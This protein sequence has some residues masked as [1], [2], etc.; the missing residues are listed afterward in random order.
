[1]HEKKKKND[2]VCFVIFNT[3][4]CVLFP[5]FFLRFPT[6]FTFFASI[7]EKKRLIFNDLDQFFYNNSCVILF[8][9]IFNFFPRSKNKRSTPKYNFFHKPIQRKIIVITKSID[10]IPIYF[11]WI[12]IYRP[13]RTLYL[14]NF[15]KYQLLKTLCKL[16]DAINPWN[17][18][19][20]F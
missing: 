17:S 19:V 2:H 12:I 13:Y 10:W 8:K 15:M 3:I 1:M 5:L 11:R 9:D 6:M 16:I 14:S 4:S 18:F 7:K 20:R